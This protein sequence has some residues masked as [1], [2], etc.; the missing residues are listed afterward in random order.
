MFES[1]I[2][3]DFCFSIDLM[4]LHL[5]E[6]NQ[7][8]LI[9]YW[10]TFFFINYLFYWFQ[11][12][13]KFFFKATLFSIH[14]F[15]YFPFIPFYFFNSNSDTLLTNM[16]IKFRESIDEFS[17]SKF[18]RKSF[19]FVAYPGGRNLWINLKENWRSGIIVGMVYVPLALSFALASGVRPCLCVL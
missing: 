19:I 6:T 13:F 3:I 10:F 15:Q 1:S 9:F 11:I 7:S 8:L 12:Q 4:H 14:S 18:V 5:H 17:F 16:M 2:L